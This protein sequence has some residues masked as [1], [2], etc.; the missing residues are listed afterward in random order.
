MK[1]TAIIIQ[2]RMGSTRL[3]GKMLTEFYDQ[4][5]LIEVIIERLQSFKFDGEIILATTRELNDNGLVKIADR[6]GVSIFRGDEE[7][8]LKR[9]I[10]SAKEFGIKK[11]IRVCAD[12]PFLDEGFFKNVVEESGDSDYCSY[13]LDEKIPTIKTHFGFFV[14]YVTLEAL[15]RILQQTNDKLYLE[16]V[17]NYIY[18][19]PENFKI[20][21][22]IVPVQILQN[23]EI[24]L[25]IDTIADFDLC[26]TIYAYFFTK[27][28]Q[29][30]ALSVIEYI[31]TKPEFLKSMRDQIKKNEK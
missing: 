22:I 1:D 15:E 26:K 17:T 6:K 27:G 16:H 8:V 23:K 13:F 9:F 24:R 10:D 7:N 14:E 11:I 21:K 2:A 29:P 12:N 31:K 3:P 20:K 25:T 19:Y 5:Q 4:K 18:T 28:E 30:S